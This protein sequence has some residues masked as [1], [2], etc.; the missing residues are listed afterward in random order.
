MAAETAT[1]LETNKSDTKEANYDSPIPSFLIE[2]G[3]KA[4][5]DGSVQ[6]AKS[7]TG[8]ATQLL[9]SSGLPVIS[10][11]NAYSMLKGCKYVKVQ[12]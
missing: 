9:E 6:I 11:F 1:V 12:G 3:Y 7:D 5:R 8:T 10:E 4:S 2:S